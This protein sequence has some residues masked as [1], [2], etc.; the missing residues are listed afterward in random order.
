MSRLYPNCAVEE[1][2]DREVLVTRSD[3]VRFKGIG[4]LR[5]TVLL[6]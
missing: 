6:E 1:V 5:K 2:G 3:G 4:W